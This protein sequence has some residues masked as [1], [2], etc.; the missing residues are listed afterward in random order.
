M[1]KNVTNFR[2][3][4]CAAVDFGIWGMQQ[5]K[6]SFPKSPAAAARISINQPRKYADIIVEL[7]RDGRQVADVAIGITPEGRFVIHTTTGSMRASDEHSIN[8]YPEKEAADAVE[9]IAAG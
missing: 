1:Q 4:A 2:K 5:L 7:Q 6:V 8:I 9:R 3:T